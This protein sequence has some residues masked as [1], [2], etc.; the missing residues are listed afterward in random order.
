MTNRF[1]AFTIAGAVVVGV[2]WLALPL[3]AAGQARKAQAGCPTKD[4]AVFH[5]CATERM[6]TF[7]PPRT[8]DGKPDMQGIWSRTHFAQDIEEHPDVIEVDAEKSMIVDPPDGKIP[9]LPWAAAQRKE[10]FAKYISPPTFCFP[11][12]IRYIHF[13][14]TQILQDP[15][16]VV[17]MQ[18]RVHD[19]RVI[20]T[21]G[22]PHVGR[23]MKLWKGDSI[24]RWEGNTLVVDVTNFNGLTWFDHAAN[25]ATDAIHIT[26]RFTMVDANTIHYEATI[27]DPAVYTRPWKM[28][29]AL[30]REREK[31]FEFMEEACHEGIRDLPQF[32]RQGFRRYPGVVPPK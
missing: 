13:G 4:P 14:D 18:E 29:M 9:Y 28:S 32:Y 6:K 2:L 25:F 11:S 10:N 15:G 19:Y 5:K 20:P 26:E 1:R 8:P 24:G 30:K 12:G 23:D 3:S 17:F 31:G 16:A 22:R 7:S 21:D 27:E